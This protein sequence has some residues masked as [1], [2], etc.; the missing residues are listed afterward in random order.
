MCKGLIIIDLQRD[1][2]SPHGIL[3]K[4]HLSSGSLVPKVN[5]IV[6]EG[7]FDIVVWVRSEYENPAAFGKLTSSRPCCIAGSSM[8][9]FVTGLSIKPE[10]E[11]FVKHFDSPFKNVELSE[12]LKKKGVTELFL[13]GV[14]RES[15]SAEFSATCKDAMSKGFS[16]TLVPECIKSIM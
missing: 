8:A 4:D 12:L 13:A 3:R 7:S 2:F 9:E 1:F 6:Q 15:G 14:S 16:V 10:H 5:K 11:I